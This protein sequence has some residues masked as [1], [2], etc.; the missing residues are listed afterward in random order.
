MMDPAVHLPPEAEKSRYDEHNNDV[1]DAGYRNFVKPLVDTVLS[2]FTPGAA[3]LDYGAGPGPVAAVMLKE[4]GYQVEL[5]DPYYWSDSRL[6]EKK[7]DFIICCEVI[8]HFYWPAREFHL[9]RSLLRPGGSLM[10]MTETIDDTFDFGQWY[11]KNDPT[12]VFFYHPRA[13][14]WIKEKYEFSILTVRKRVI[15]LEV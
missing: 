2:K 12:H 13:L 3:G 11:Y 6:L 1:N 9:L 5:F 8:E 15:H 10:C 4:K 7:Y 14:R